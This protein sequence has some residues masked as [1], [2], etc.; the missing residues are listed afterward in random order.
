M[1]TVLQS[2][3]AISENSSPAVCLLVGVASSQ[4]DHTHQQ[5]KQALKWCVQQGF[6]LVQWERGASVGEEEEE[7]EGVYMSRFTQYIYYQYYVSHTA[8]PEAVGVARVS[9]ALQA[10]MWTD[11]V[12]KQGGGECVC[13]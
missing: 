9:E 3:A 8:F 2:W 6:E 12:M 4:A 11:M 13:V 1:D 5:Q 10:H 7:E